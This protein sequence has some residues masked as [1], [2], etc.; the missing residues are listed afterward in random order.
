MTTVRQD[1]SALGRVVDLVRDLR[2]R[3]PWDRAQTRETLRPYL[4]EE[5]LELDHS[6]GEATGGIGGPGGQGGPAGPAGSGRSTEIRDELGDLM[7]HFAFQIV[8]GEEKGE[9][10]AEDVARAIE[11]KMWRRHPHLYPEKAG[12]LVG[13][14]GPGGPGEN[15]HTQRSWERNKRR[16]RRTARGGVLDGL[17]P[18]LPALIMAH[19]LQERAAGVGFDWTDE[20]GPRDKIREELDELESELHDHRDQERLEHE[21][22]DL[23]FAVVNLARKVGVDS[24]AALEKANR[25]FQER[26]GKVEALA[27]E[28]GIDIGS[29]GLE[30]LDELWEEVKGTDL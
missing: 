23:L 27:A 10:G 14:G 22:G 7:L 15:D 25:R 16:E 12:G 6:I 2:Q 3:C 28:R 30:E 11:E 21:L 5:V 1:S 4:V 8:I 9:F 17:P 24:R 26:F 18:S 20:R 19:R 13:P 29:A